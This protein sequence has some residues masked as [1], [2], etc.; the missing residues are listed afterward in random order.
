MR[1]IVIPAHV[2]EKAAFS[3]Q[4]GGRCISFAVKVDWPELQLTEEQ[5]YENAIALLDGRELPFPDHSVFSIEVPYVDPHR[6]S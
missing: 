6:R 4:I 3:N 2:I 5:I 1:K